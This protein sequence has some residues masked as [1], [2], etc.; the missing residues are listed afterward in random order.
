MSFFSNLGTLYGGLHNAGGAKRIGELI[1][2][3]QKTNEWAEVYNAVTNDISNPE[4]LRSVVFIPAHFFALDYVTKGIYC[5]FQW[6][7]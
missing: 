1:D 6:V 7:L 5:R 4:T 3:Y 2:V